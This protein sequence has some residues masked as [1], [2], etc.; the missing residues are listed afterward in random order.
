MSALTLTNISN[1]E[2]FMYS[3]Q[4]LTF[5]PI[6]LKMTIV[7]VIF[8][9]ISPINRVIFVMNSKKKHRWDF[10]I[11]FDVISNLLN[12]IN[13][14]LIY[15]SLYDQSGNFNFLLNHRI[16]YV[17]FI[18]LVTC[19]NWIKLYYYF[20]C[21]RG[22]SALVETLVNIFT[23]TI[24]FLVLLL[25]YF[26]IMTTVFY[27]LYQKLIP[28]LYGQFSLSLNTLFDA[29][30]FS[31]THPLII[32]PIEREKYDRI[33]RIFF[34]IHVFIVG[35]LLVNYL[36]SILS[37]VFNET[38]D[39]EYERDFCYYSAIYYFNS[40]YRPGMLDKKHGNLL[41]FLPPF[42]LIST[43][44]SVF[45]MSKYYEIIV[46]IIEFIYFFCTS[47]LIFLIY[48][49]YLSILSPILM[50]KAFT[51]IFSMNLNISRKGLVFFTWI[52]IGPIIVIISLI[53]DLFNFI[54]I[55]SL[56]YFPS[57]TSKLQKDYEKKLY[58]EIFNQSKMIFSSININF[59]E[60]IH[61]KS[62]FIT[63]PNLLHYL[64]KQKIDDL[65][66]KKINKVIDYKSQ[67]TTIK[68][69]HT[70]LGKY[71]QIRP[72][73][74]IIKGTI[75]SFELSLLNKKTNIKAND[76]THLDISEKIEKFF[77]N[78]AIPTIKG[79]I[80]NLH[81]MKI[82]FERTIHYNNINKIIDLNFKLMGNTLNKLENQN[83]YGILEFFESLNKN[84]MLKIINKVKI[85]E[86]NVKKI[87]KNHGIT[88]FKNFTRNLKNRISFI[89]KIET[90]KKK[91]KETSENINEDPEKSSNN[92]MNNL[93]NS[94]RDTTR[95]NKN[96]RVLFS[97]I[98]DNKN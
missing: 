25:C 7:L 59:K 56:N 3:Y 12:L 87:M 95:K 91:N 42:N 44:C 68:F 76:K 67:N 62:L 19:L 4:T 11:I 23:S 37:L 28:N 2:L 69:M 55:L 53:R 77:N 49:I 34:S 31:Y 64:F 61:N 81:L 89:N 66:Y 82:I 43:V 20:K 10:N 33:Y 75:N 88:D 94:V 51:I 27:I 78:F 41:L 35:V 73:G 9:L 45:I 72:A 14:S 60:E 21:F 71:L 16:S 98:N 90:S 86:N 70:F 36:V 8:N 6:W 13:M 84:R 29:I 1:N 5:S 52:F 38:N 46:K 15:G 80:I 63:V 97:E 39:E 30:V 40:R 58:I 24:Y 96:N 32:D 57:E 26:L 17:Y 74:H 65:V 79:D 47:L 85:L 50:L 54:Y 93:Y 83:P 18:T 48:F 92:F 22:T